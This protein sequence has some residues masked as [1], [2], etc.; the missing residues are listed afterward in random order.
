[1]PELAEVEFNRRQWDPGLGEKILRTSIHA[2]KRIFRGTD[3]ALLEEALKGQ[4]L[5]HSEARA[6]QMLFHFSGDLWLGVHLGM[7]GHLRV[8]PPGFTPEK[9][10][11]LALFQKRRT[12]LLRDS[13]LFGR[14]RVEQC[15]TPPEWWTSLPPAVT[16]P[17]WT[18]EVLSTFLQRRG[19]LAVKGAILVQSAF[20]GVGNWMADEILWRARIDPRQLSG[21]L[22]RTQLR[23][24]WE[25]SRYVCE[26][27]LATIA[28]DYSDPPAD[29]LFHVRWSRVGRCP[30]DKSPLQTATVGG[31]TTRWCARCQKARK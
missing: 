12:L 27:A 30:R 19:K 17:E 6:K 3:V 21:T 7:T 1:M 24:L 4:K 25:E 8:E 14:V 29:W 26:I 15:R 13:R 31:R 28:V 16:S 11:H 2:E 18:Q 20:P 23:R 10:D 5:L 22:T 9:H